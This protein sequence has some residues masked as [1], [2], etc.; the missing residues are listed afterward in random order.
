MSQPAVMEPQVS[1]PVQQIEQLTNRMAQVETE[2]ATVK[3]EM[4]WL[5]ANFRNAAK[6]TNGYHA[7]AA[8]LPDTAEWKPPTPEELAY[9]QTLS[10]DE[11]VPIHYMTDTDVREYLD[12]FEQKYNISSE[13]FYA[14]WKRGEADDI[15]EKT[16]WSILY[17]DWQQIVAAPSSANEE[18][19]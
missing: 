4:Q 18:R 17:E 5:L 14:R 19:V 6:P 8:P 3:A 1:A 9:L 12:E 15:I 10:E 16:A 11:L 7:P 2:L 13:E